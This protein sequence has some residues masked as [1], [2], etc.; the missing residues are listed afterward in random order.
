M[1]AEPLQSVGV[2]GEIQFASRLLELLHL[3]LWLV[4]AVDGGK[5]RVLV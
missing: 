3:P 2:A 4:V 5:D 1:V